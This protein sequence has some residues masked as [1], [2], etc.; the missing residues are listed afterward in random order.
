MAGVSM[1]PGMGAFDAI[2]GVMDK[3]GGFINSPLGK[4]AQVCFRE[5]S[6]VLQ[7]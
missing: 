2:G 3:V 7:V 4:L 1:I 6:W 5:T